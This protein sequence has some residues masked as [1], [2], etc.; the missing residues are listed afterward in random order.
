MAFRYEA[1]LSVVIGVRRL[2]GFI[3][4]SGFAQ[5]AVSRLGVP[6]VGE[7]EVDQLAVLVDSTKNKYFHLPPTR[8]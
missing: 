7:H 1:S 2:V 8:T 3:V 5:E 4:F 6:S